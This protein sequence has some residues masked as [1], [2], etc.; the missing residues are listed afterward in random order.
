MQ[1]PVAAGGDGE[2][3]TPSAQGS[4]CLRVVSPPEMPFLRGRRKELPPMPTSP[5]PD[6]E[7]TGS[8]HHPQP[9]CISKGKGAFG[10]PVSS[11]LLRTSLVQVLQ[12]PHC[13]LFSHSS[14]E[15]LVSSFST[16]E[17]DWQL[18]KRRVTFYLRWSLLFTQ[19]K[20]SQSLMSF[21]C[22]SSTPQ[23]DITEEIGTP[24]NRRYWPLPSC[25]SISTHWE[26]P[27]DP[28]LI[29]RNHFVFTF[30]ALPQSAL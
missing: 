25:N 14:Q 19:G 20:L 1:G 21:P 30:T 2:V 3:T 15:G 11:R 4:E 22:N 5:T 10:Y 18:K 27:G 12:Q 23:R 13:L 8:H 29:V 28:S 17:R 9:S 16:Q 24:K 26:R 6:A 7:C